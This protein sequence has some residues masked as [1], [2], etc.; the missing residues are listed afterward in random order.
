[1]NKYV[2]TTTKT[3]VDGTQTILQLAPHANRGFKLLSM[4]VSFDGAA[5]AAGITVELVRQTTAGTG[6]GSP[7]TPQEYRTPGDAALATVTHNHSAEPTLG[8]VLHS[9]YVSPFGG[10]IYKQFPLDLEPHA[11]AGGDR[12]GVRVIAPAGVNPN[13][14]V[15]LE[16]E[17]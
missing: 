14:K 3:L 7:P 1:M 5:A 12:L 2:V 13:C 4:G 11:E 17:E 16:F 10:N 15:T 6:A 8:A 9:E